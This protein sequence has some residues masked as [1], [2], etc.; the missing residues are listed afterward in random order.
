MADQN[1]SDNGAPPLI[2]VPPDFH[3]EWEIY[4]VLITSFQKEIY[5]I[6]VITSFQK[7]V[8]NF[9][10]ASFQLKLTQF[11][12]LLHF[13]TGFYNSCCYFNSK[14]ISISV[15]NSFQKNF[16]LLLRF[17]RGVLIFCHYLISKGKMLAFRGDIWHHE[18]TV[19]EAKVMCA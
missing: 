5:S 9:L 14:A 18:V 17:R 7:E 19:C 13:E 8:F 12:L 6:I 3:F 15:I 2:P 1:A 10:S 16:H 4:N 11:V